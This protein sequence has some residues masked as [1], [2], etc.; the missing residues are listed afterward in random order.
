LQNFAYVSG[1]IGLFN[2]LP[3]TP[4]DGGHVLRAALSYF[5]DRRR[6][7]MAAALGGVIVAGVIVAFAA[8]RG[9]IWTAFI[10]G[11]LG[12]VAW[13]ELQRLRRGE[14]SAEEHG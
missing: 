5:M 11:L 10:G 8:W 9:L 7:A 4:L 2:L 3:G 12:L 13:G 14:A 6:A 1:L